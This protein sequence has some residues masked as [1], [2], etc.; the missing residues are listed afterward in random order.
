MTDKNLSETLQ[1][2]INQGDYYNQT[3]EQ[4]NIFNKQIHHILLEYKNSGGEQLT[5]R[6]IVEQIALT[7]SDNEFLQDVAYDILDIITD[8]CQPEI[9]VWN[10]QKVIHLNDGLQFEDDE[11]GVIFNHFSFCEIIKHTMVKYGKINYELASEKIN[12]SHLI[13]I[14]R[15]IK[16]IEFL[17][18]ELDY[19]WAMLLVH[20]DMYW[21]KGISSDFNKF[22]DEY[23]A[24]RTE[25][26]QKYNLKESY[27]YYDKQ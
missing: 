4:L 9:R 16:D 11:N 24:W 6:E 1:K 8:W 3:I 27:K 17:T 26:K 7:V 14:P 5:A 10:S 2:I 18:H 22:E 21:T 13:K 15:T 23:F 19:H 20:G 25:I 12:N